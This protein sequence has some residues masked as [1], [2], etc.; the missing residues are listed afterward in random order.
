MNEILVGKKAICAFCGRSW[1]VVKG[2]I[3]REGFPAKKMEGVWE[4]DKD[5]ISSWRKDQILKTC[6]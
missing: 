6:Q 3:E 2:W 5:L 1:Q 4:S